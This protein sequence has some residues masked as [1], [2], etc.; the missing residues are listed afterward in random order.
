MLFNY[1]Y[2]ILLSS[3][4]GKTYD[5]KNMSCNQYS[6]LDKI[7]DE[8]WVVSRLPDVRRYGIDNVLIRLPVP[9][10]VELRRQLLLV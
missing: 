10:R 4:F 8:I 7:I 9:L 5:E 6:S 2:N 3:C 1:T